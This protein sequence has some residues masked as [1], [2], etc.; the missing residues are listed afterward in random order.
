MTKV[1]K[2]SRPQILNIRTFSGENDSIL[3]KIAESIQD[4]RSVEIIQLA[5]SMA[6]TMQNHRGIGL[7]APQVGQSLRLIVFNTSYNPED[8]NDFWRGLTCL[9]NPVILKET[10]KVNSEEGCLSLPGQLITVGRAKH[11]KVRGFDVLKGKIITLKYTGTE[12]RCIQHEIDHLN[13]LLLIDKN[14]NA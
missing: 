6:L 5:E 9:A 3:R 11:I 12:A 7:A 8:D 4:P 14:E 1:V 10:G 13:G 2:M